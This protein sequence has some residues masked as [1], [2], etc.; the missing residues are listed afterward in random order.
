MRYT[1]DAISGLAFGAD[2][3][4]LESDDD[5]IQRHLDKIFPAL[6]KRIFGAFPYWRYIKLPADRQLARSVAEVGSAIEK[7]IAAARVRLKDSPE[8]RE[9]PRNL[10][11]AMLVAADEA[12]SGIDDQ[13]VIGNVQT[14][15]LAGEDTTANTLAW[16]IY[17]LQRNPQA[18]QRA[19]K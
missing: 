18:L 8:R 17:L 5:I 6:N 10:L 14:M 3:N 19:K 12:G 7:F 9:S 2:V 16:M 13:M 4:T 1:V 15:L 11:E